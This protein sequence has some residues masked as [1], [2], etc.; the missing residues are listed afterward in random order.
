MGRAGAL[1]HLTAGVLPLVGSARRTGERGDVEVLVAAA[2]LRLPEG[3]REG[4]GP[5]D[6]R[7]DPREEYCHGR[8]RPARP[9]SHR[10][11]SPRRPVT[12]EPTP[13][14]PSLRRPVSLCGDSAEPIGQLP[15][16][17]PEVST[18]A[19]WLLGYQSRAREAGWS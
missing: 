5:G 7:E 1:H 16:E 19:A 12:M 17:V 14:A 18:S 10:R 11:P 9:K 2:G 4:L 13:A 3:E 6:A 8:D 15:P